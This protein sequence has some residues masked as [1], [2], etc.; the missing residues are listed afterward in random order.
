MKL[1]SGRVVVAR[2]APRP[3]KK[4]AVRAVAR[5]EVRKEMRK[6]IS[7]RRKYKTSLN[8]AATSTATLVNYTIASDIEHGDALDGRTADKIVLKGINI[9][10][11]AKNLDANK[12]AY[13]R[14]LLV[15]RKEPNQGLNKIFQG[16]TTVEGSN[17]V[18]T[19][20]S[21]QV[22][23]PINRNLFAVTMDKKIRLLP[24]NN[25]SQGRM[26]TYKTYFKRL[27]KKIIYNAVSGGI[28]NPNYHLFAF[29]QWDDGNVTSTADVRVDI[30]TYFEDI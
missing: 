5:A 22:H 17:Y 10:L 19:G 11:E 9:K 6:H 4:R 18:T 3:R 2:R 15:K 7:L 23:W 16:T 25:N 24:D 8:A 30:Y 28:V 27:N 14:L 1:R 26:K 21:A 12:P 29:L 20:D 13:L